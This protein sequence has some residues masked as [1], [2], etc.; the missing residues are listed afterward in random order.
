[1]GAAPLT[2][3]RPGSAGGPSGWEVAAAGGASPGMGGRRRPPV[4]RDGGLEVGAVPPGWPPQ[5]A[6]P[7]RRAP[8]RRSIP[9]SGL[10]PRR[11]AV[12]RPRLRAPPRPRPPV[13]RGLVG[14][15]LV[16]V[17][18]RLRGRPACSGSADVATVASRGGPVSGR[19][20]GFLA[21][22]SGW[23]ARHGQL[24]RLPELSSPALGDSSGVAAS[25][26][27]PA[28]SGS[29]CSGADSSARARG[30]SG[31]SGGRAGRR[32]RPAA[33]A[34]AP[35]WVEGQGPL[36]VLQ[37]AGRP[38]GCL[39]GSSP[40]L[41]PPSALAGLGGPGNPEAPRTSR[42]SRLDYPASVRS[43]D[44]AWARCRAGPCRSRPL[45]ATSP[46]LRAAAFA[47][48]D[49]GSAAH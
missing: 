17:R 30:R 5:V 14:P 29:G 20:P 11:P 43:P 13:R 33:T 25:P 28:G 34:A 4:P 38:R 12:H 48:P 36:G 32:V 3:A 18:R 42:K 10:G 45:G 35:S 6:L 37:C 9:V 22:G 8:G 16:R 1:M 19:G 26:D 31:S 7:R 49:R 24:F 46:G 47:G 15:G 39:V 40:A 23:V 21:W 27:S 44:Q 41:P 2:A